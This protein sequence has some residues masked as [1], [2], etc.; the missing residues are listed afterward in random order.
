MKLD[1]PEIFPS[2]SCL[3][4]PP[5]SFVSLRSMPFLVNEVWLIARVGQK[6][7][8]GLPKVRLLASYNGLNVLV[9]AGQPGVC[10]DGSKLNGHIDPSQRVP[11]PLLD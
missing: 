11:Q 5:H 8:E 9:E 10:R 3:I 1:P 4:S 6:A 2:Q 7:A